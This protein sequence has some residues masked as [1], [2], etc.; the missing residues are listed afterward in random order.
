[1]ADNV[2]VALGRA[3]GASV[4]IGA[5]VM[6]AAITGEAA[7]GAGAATVGLAGGTPATS[8]G[9]TNLFGGAFGGG[10]ASV[11]ILVRARSAAD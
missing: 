10:V 2:T 5:G 8:V 3:V 4:A 6:V 7:G 1:M 9:F 11:L